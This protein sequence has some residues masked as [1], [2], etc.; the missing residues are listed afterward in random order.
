MFASLLFITALSQGPTW[1]LDPD[2]A[3]RSDGSRWIAFGAR[4]A[5]TPDA[6]NSAL[7]AGVKDLMIDWSPSVP[8]ETLKIAD[9]KGASYFLA[10]NS[11]PPSA[12]GIFVEPEAYRF[13]PFSGKAQIK[14]TIPGASRALI[15][16]A[17]ARDATIT[18]GRSVFWVDTP[19]GVLDVPVTSD[20]VTDR[21]ALIF[22]EAQSVRVPDLGPAFDAHRDRMLAKLKSMGPASGFRGILDPIGQLPSFAPADLQTVPTSERFRREFQLELSQK[23]G[24]PQ[25]A[26][27]AWEI[28]ASDIAEFTVLARLFPLFS[29]LRGIP[30][31]VDPVTLKTY[32]VNRQRSKIWEDLRGS[33]ISQ[34]RRRYLGLVG[35]IKQ[36]TQR[37]V[38]QTWS[39]WNGPYGSA[40]SGID[41]I[42]VRLE[43]SA[44]SE[45][46]AQAGRAASTNAG[47]TTPRALL[48]TDM[49]LNAG[50]EMRDYEATV[51]E[52]S[53]LGVRGW[54]FRADSAT[55]LEWIRTMGE[56]LKADLAQPR[57]R[58]MLLPFPEAATDPIM[59]GRVSPGVWAVPAPSDGVRLDLGGPLVGYQFVGPDDRFFVFWSSEGP[60]KLKMRS[61][62]PKL[63]Q[64]TLAD[65]TTPQ[66]RLSKSHLELTVG[67]IPV[68]LRGTERFP[69]PEE[70]IAWTQA[71]FQQIV[72]QI[73]SNARSLLDELVAY[74]NAQSNLSKDPDAFSKMRNQLMRLRIAL[75]PG[76]WIE[77]EVSRAYNWSEVASSPGASGNRT[78]M[79]RARVTPPTGFY[80]SD[81]AATPSIDG[82]QRIWVTAKGAADAIELEV[83]GNRFKLTGPGL[84][85][86]GNGLRWYAFPEMNLPAQLINFRLQVAGSFSGDVE[87]DRLVILPANRR[88]TGAGFSS[89]A[90]GN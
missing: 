44:F 22:P 89:V 87:L 28:A 75:Q 35:A 52:G 12:K 62:D 29:E 36:A 32:R 34:S 59:A 27:I 56:R 7:D 21:V 39:G 17:S 1:S 82:M 90:I 67:S 15:V 5:G 57:S 25:R 60:I 19:N 38:F 45:V 4:V 69:V 71:E 11:L 76:A 55:G 13:G 83:L 46:M 61:A 78:L 16:F 23:Y 72:G 14:A 77:A 8:E 54:F 26:A 84:L 30:F 68:I 20:A 2:G 70:A 88:P 86:H 48:Q 42:G 81:Y 37:P 79:L 18:E 80:F 53:D 31:L 41:G 40:G 66:V 47:S 24:T 6:I 3:L 74:R 9:S 58:P 43:Q 50:A 33:V 64:V 10:V 65:G 85:P 49:T 63:V 51:R 73:P